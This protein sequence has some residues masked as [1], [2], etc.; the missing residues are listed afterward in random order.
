MLIL[1]S[2]IDMYEE[3]LWNDDSQILTQS[4]LAKQLYLDK[5]Y[6]KKCMWEQEPKKSTHIITGCI[7][8][9]KH[10]IVTQYL[11]NLSCVWCFCDVCRLFAYISICSVMCPGC[12]LSTRLYWIYWHLETAGLLLDFLQHASMSHLLISIIWESQHKGV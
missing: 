12:C 3:T 6:D 9:L 7:L 1:I 10:M 4:I 5:M 8:T 2:I 11:Q